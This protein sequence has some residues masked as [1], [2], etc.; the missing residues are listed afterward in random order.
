MSPSIFETAL[1]DLKGL[2]SQRLVD[3]NAA[4]TVNA[5]DLPAAKFRDSSCI[6][7]HLAAVP[8]AEITG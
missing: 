3:G 6:G 8:S 1:L 2:T 5:S 4:G 7:S